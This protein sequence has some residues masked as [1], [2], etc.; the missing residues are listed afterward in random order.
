L[1]VSLYVLIDDWWKLN[2]TSEQPNTSGPAVLSDSELITVAILAQW[3]R[4]RTE[5]DIWRLACSHL[6]APTSLSLCA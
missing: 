1:L 3:S 2:H 4:I 5:R 6:C